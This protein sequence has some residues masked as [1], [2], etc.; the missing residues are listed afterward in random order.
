MSAPAL[1]VVDVQQAFDDPSWGTRNNTACE[2]NI[3][4]LIEHWRAEERPIVF[5]R[6]DSDEPRSTL[7]PATRATRSRTSSR[8]SRTCS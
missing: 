4:A 8:A 3:A 6:H 7:A 2:A 5:V 1:I